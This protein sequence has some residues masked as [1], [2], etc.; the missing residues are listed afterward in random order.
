MTLQQHIGSQWRGVADL[1]RLPFP[2]QYFPAPYTV[3]PHPAA[4]HPHPRQLS[5]ILDIPQSGKKGLDVS[6]NGR[7][8]QVRR[9]LVIPT[10]PRTASQMT[11]RAKLSIVAK[12]RRTLTE[13]QRQAWNSADNT[14][15]STAPL[16]QS[17]P[18][19]GLQLFIKVNATLA[20]FGQDQVDTPPT[21]PS[22]DKLAPQDLTATSTGGVVALKLTCPTSPGQ[23]TII[24]ASAPHPD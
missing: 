18:L 16:G 19:T 22:F 5:K 13:N 7:N 24:R 4:S 17:G 21:Y 12:H 10:N 14:Y 3:I 20:E 11:V 15:S 1:G 23:N 9:T 2:T 8:G 6:M